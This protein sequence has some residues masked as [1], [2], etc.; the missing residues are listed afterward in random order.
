MKVITYTRTGNKST[1]VALAKAIF[2]A[3]VS[4]DLLKQAVVR[5]QSNL[6]QGDSKVLTRGEVRGGG[7]KPWRQKGTGRARFGSSRVN[8]WRHGGVTHGPTGL[9]NYQKDMPKTMVRTSIKMALSAQAE[10]IKVIEQFS[11]AEPKTKLADQLLDKLDANGNVLLVHAGVDD[12]FARSV[13]NLPGVLLVRFNQLRSY[14]ILVA[15][16]IVIE[17]PAL[18]EIENWLGKK[19]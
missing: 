19:S 5:A 17:K 15:D 9:V 14:D 18:A 8:I 4:Q 13:A 10:A 7:R 3:K 11:V 6:R 12:I 1:E 2:E 16:S